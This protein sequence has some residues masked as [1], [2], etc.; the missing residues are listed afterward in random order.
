MSRA[1]TQ[2]PDSDRL[3]VCNDGP[4]IDAAEAA[5]ILAAERHGYTKASLFAVRL[6]VHEALMNGFKHGHKGLPANLPVTLT[7]KVKDRTIEC[8]IEDQGPGFTPQDVP[9]PTLEENIERGSGRG[10]LLIR[11]YMSRVE[12]NTKGN[13]VTMVYEKP[14]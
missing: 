6:A 3:A 8:T 11:A 4:S 14:D 10:L 2:A 5:V 12:H 7:Y 13:R 9:D 1:S